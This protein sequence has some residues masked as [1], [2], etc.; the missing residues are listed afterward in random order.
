M[1]SASRVRYASVDRRRFPLGQSRPC[2]DL[3]IVM[4]NLRVFIGLEVEPLT[5]KSAWK[6]DGAL[7]TP[8]MKFTQTR[9]VH[10]GVDSAHATNAADVVSTT[11]PRILGCLVRGDDPYCNH[12]KFP[13]LGSRLLCQSSLRFEAYHP[14]FHLNS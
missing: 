13:S 7:S 3:A 4:A 1:W 6:L 11:Y 9:K 14:L 10:H 8:C 2:L 5:A 12:M